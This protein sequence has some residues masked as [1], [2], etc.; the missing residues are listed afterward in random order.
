[1]T[2][3]SIKNALLFK[4][5]I[6][7]IS[8]IVNE[9]V[10]KFRKNDIEIYAISPDNVIVIELLI[11]RKNLSGYV[12]KPT[13]NIALNLSCLKTILSRF[14]SIKGNLRMKIY[15]DKIE[16]LAT[17]NKLKKTFCISIVPIKNNPGFPRFKPNVWWNV[18]GVVDGISKMYM[19]LNKG[20]LV[21]ES[22]KDEFPLKWIIAPI[23]ITKGK[24]TIR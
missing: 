15:G 2:Q 22:I 10:F 18:E 5:K 12:Y 6:N 11:P 3:F 1:M 20:P 13:K 17:D 21:I 4:E 19:W 7:A 14:K 23:I 24:R 16:I 9:S 8:N